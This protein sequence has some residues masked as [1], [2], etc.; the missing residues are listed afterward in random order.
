[1]LSK[2]EAIHARCLDCSAGLVTERE[3]CKIKD[4]PL[5]PFRNPKHT[6]KRGSGLSRVKAIYEYC[7]GCSG[8]SQ[9]ERELCVSSNCPLYP[10]RNSKANSASKAGSDGSSGKRKRKKVSD[11]D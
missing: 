5:H 1:M 3:R 10:Y 6:I 2:T 9:T 11:I 8:G 7:L 4:C